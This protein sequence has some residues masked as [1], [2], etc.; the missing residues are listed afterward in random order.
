MVTTKEKWLFALPFILFGASVI[1]ALFFLFVLVPYYRLLRFMGLGIGVF[2]EYYDGIVSNGM[3][4]E[5][6]TQKIETYASQNLNNF[7]GASIG[8][9]LQNFFLKIPKFL[10]MV[11]MFRKAFFDK[12]Y[13][14]TMSRG[15]NALTNVSILLFFVAVTAFFMNLGT[16][17][18]ATRIMSMSTFPILFL[19]NYVLVGRKAR[20]IPM[21]TM[22]FFLGIE[23]T[24]IFSIYYISVHGI[25]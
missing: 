19:A 13:V 22:C 24:Y 17:T 20:Y 14:R 10:F 3:D 2:Q 21:M 15:Q 8:E 9:Y 16:G 6:Y 12:S 5:Y 25:V 23:L 7:F 4:D 11:Y 18:I 1:M